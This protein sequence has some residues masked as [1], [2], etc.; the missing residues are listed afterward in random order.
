MHTI[1]LLLLGLVIAGGTGWGALA[2]H[3]LAPGPS[4]VRL[5][6]AWIFGVLGLAT[7]VSLAFPR[8]RR[9]VILVFGAAFVGVLLV[10]FTTRPSND[11]DWQT[12]VAVLPTVQINGDVVTV[13]NS[14]HLGHLSRWKRRA[15]SGHRL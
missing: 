7:L 3:Y 9:N 13:H 4:G 10:F 5:V 11:R 2:L 6:L 15:G 12:N 14:E 1:G 8:F